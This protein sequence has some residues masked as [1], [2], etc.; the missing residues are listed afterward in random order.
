M[1][2]PTLR[3]WM[4]RLLLVMVF[5]SGIFQGEAEAH[6]FITD[7]KQETYTKRICRRVH[8]LVDWE[9]CTEE[10]LGNEAPDAHIQRAARSRRVAESRDILN[11]GKEYPYCPLML[12]ERRSAEYMQENSGRGIAVCYAHRQDGKKNILCISG[13]ETDCFLEN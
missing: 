10:Q 1:K 3:R 12:L 13:Q 2:R 9:V 11:L 6:S 8:R 4:C 7:M 5:F